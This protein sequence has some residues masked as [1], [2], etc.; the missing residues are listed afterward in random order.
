MNFAI[1]SQI[2]FLVSQVS[3]GGWTKNFFKLIEPY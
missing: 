2:I 3:R 1:N